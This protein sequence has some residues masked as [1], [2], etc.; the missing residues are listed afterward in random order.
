[1]PGTLLGILH[2]L[3]HLSV[4][5]TPADQY[6]PGV[7]WFVDFSFFLQELSCESPGN[8][9]F[10]GK[11]GQN[12]A[13]HEQH[14]VQRRQVWGRSGKQSVKVPGIMCRGR[15]GWGRAGRET[16]GESVFSSLARA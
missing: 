10:D 14:L 5:E 12:F 6:H 15:P 16:E 3:S 13:E 8:D 9:Y 2:S 1:M 7:N 4:S 11:E